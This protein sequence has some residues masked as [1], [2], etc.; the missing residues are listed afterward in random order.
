MTKRLGPLVLLAALAGAPAAQAQSYPARTITLTVTAAAGGVTDVVAR[1][2]GQR[3]AQ[4]WGQQVVIENKGGAAHVVGAQSVAKAAPDGY[5]LLVAEAGTFT[6]NPT[7]YGNGKLPYDE[8]KDF[9]PITGIVRINQALLGHPSLPANDVRELIELARKTPGELTYGTAGI[10]SAPHMNMVLFESMTGVKLVPV[11][12]RGAA[13]ALTDV[14]A[15]HV[16]LM[17]VSVS[18]ALPPFR[19]GQIKI[20]GVGSGK[21]MPLAPDIPTVAENG[22]PGYEATTWFGLFATAG[23]PQ[24]IVT[25]INAEVAKTLADPQFREK[26]LAPQMFEP[27]ASSP[28]EFADYIKAQTRKWAKVIHEQKLSIEK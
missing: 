17:S 26:F 15:G 11:H 18:L 1:A 12:Y 25:K 13:P 7:L 10:G 16:K 2:L 4:A 20:F 24:P 27:M 19:T 8:E 14:I 6:I 21:R 9:I 23:T 22:L 28:E 3:L 5:S